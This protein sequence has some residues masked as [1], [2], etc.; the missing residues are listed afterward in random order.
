VPYYSNGLKTNRDAWCYNSSQQVLTAAV[1]KTIKFYNTE[2]E[3]YYSDIEAGKKIANIQDYID[4][5]PTKISWSS[6]LIPEVQRRHRMKFDSGKIVCGMYR[7]FMKQ[8]AYFD[9]MMNDRP[10]QM[11]KLSPRRSM[12]TW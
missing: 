2:V 8:F 11:P 12:K 9:D 10:G 4:N 5:N 6:S 7:P 1:K 3:R